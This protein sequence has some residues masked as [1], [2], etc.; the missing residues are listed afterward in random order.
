MREI[1]HGRARVGGSK[2]SPEQAA[3]SHAAGRLQLIPRWAALS[4][5][6]GVVAETHGAGRPLEQ[7]T[8]SAMEAR[9][10][11]DLSGVRVHDDEA[12]AASA[13][14]LGARA[15][16]GGSHIV[17]GRGLYQPAH[18]GGQSL[19]A[20]ELAHVV[21]EHTAS[22][23]LRR[24]PLGPRPPDQAVTNDPIPMEEDL[25]RFSKQ[26]EES[27][28][29][30]SPGVGQEPRSAISVKASTD[31]GTGA[32]DVDYNFSASA[33]GQRGSISSN[34]NLHLHRE[35]DD[36]DV[37]V[38]PTNPELHLVDDPK[39]ATPYMA[40]ISYS[41]TISYADEY[42]RTLEVELE[43]VVLFSRKSLQSTAAQHE[44][45]LTAL[46]RLQ[47]DAGYMS[48]RITGQGNLANLM[49]H[50]YPSMPAKFKDPILANRSLSYMAFATMDGNSLQFLSGD[51]AGAL[52]KT[53]GSFPVHLSDVAGNFV[54]LNRTAGQQYDDIRAYLESRDKVYIA[55]W[56]AEI[57]ESLK[58]PSTLVSGAPKSGGG[59][60]G[61]D[62]AAAKKPGWLDSLLRAIGDFWDSLPVP[63]RAAIKEIG[64]AVGS[65]A[66]IVGLAV[67]IVALA[68]V[69]LTVA[70][71]ALAIGGAL[72]IGSFLK[73][74]Y[75][76]SVE[77]YET[78]SG[79]PL[80]VFFIAIGD[81]LGITAIIEGATNKSVLS[82]T[83][84]NLGEEGQWEK[85]IGGGIQFLLMVLGGRSALEEKAPV[86]DVVP[87]E[88]SR[89]APE[90]APRSPAQEPLF[91]NLSDAEVDA[92]L[93]GADAPTVT[94]ERS[95]PR[96]GGRRV[97]DIQRR[98]FDIEDIPRRIGETARQAVARINGVISHTLDEFPV[99]RDAW[100]Q[101]RDQ[102]IAERGAL[103]RD[104]YLELYDATRKQFWR[105]VRDNNAA[106]QAFENAGFEFPACRTT[107]PVLR[108]APQDV[109]AQEF[110]I[111]LDHILEKAQGNNWQY[112]LD[113]DNLRM[114]FQNPNSYREA[115]Q[116]RHPDLRPLSPP[117]TSSQAGD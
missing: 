22:D 115:I 54:Y 64:I 39:L 75:V 4:G 45:T 63:L 55:D 117:P 69:E 6:S 53:Q 56:V 97:P 62:S 26:E 1:G 67:V 38:Q 87:T 84:L 81:T 59:T 77:S 32:K 85:G 52:E 72:M 9:M 93:E 105:N 89:A 57:E 12:A 51:I 80:S 5:T 108:G 31:L 7:P 114:E 60:I 2:E 36:K 82:G 15:F 79:N 99:L 110:R 102:I 14:A 25:G 76:R 70:G 104:N 65:V 86:T 116:A 21:G 19:L 50:D 100:Q 113:P 20:H 30:V 90:L 18:S 8:L 48:V 27:L 23:V 58:N 83:P 91:E 106:R 34:T 95:D 88:L 107:A 47:G 111:S 44:M 92:A 29:T 94:S 68:P 101:A 103:T 109:S 78:H 112:A 42:G 3:A 66:A 74:I 71:V 17:F 61:P 96:I 49:S 43:S 73:S 13:E 98:R 16:T 35:P 11:A 46:E 24:S 28:R 33:K 40:T 41:R 10:G 37:L